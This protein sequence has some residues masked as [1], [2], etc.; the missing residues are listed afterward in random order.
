MKLA[1]LAPQPNSGSWSAVPHVPWS[2]SRNN[3]ESRW[4][5]WTK[6]M[7]EAAECSMDVELTPGQCEGERTPRPAC[8]R[9][10]G[11][12]RLSWGREGRGHPR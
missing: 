11:C 4:M 2:R 7:V 12:Y 1:L 5:Q 10:R 6:G 8:P 3:G 9:L